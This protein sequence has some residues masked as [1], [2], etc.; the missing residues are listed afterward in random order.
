MEAFPLQSEKFPY[1]IP[2]FIEIAKGSNIK[3]EWN[4]EHKT[5][6]L[7]RILHSSVMYP[8]NYG[9]IPQTLCDDGDPLDV[10]VMSNKVLQPGTI[11]YVRPICH[12]DMEDEKGNDEKLLAIVD[13]EPD[14]HHVRTIDDIA[15][16]KFAEISEFFKTY[17]NLEP[18]K[19]SKVKDWSS[20]VDT[21]RLIRTTHDN[22][23]KKQN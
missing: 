11:V 1:I 8:E 2:A 18:N 9:F 4:D 23:S 7:D 5:L 10:L 20:S 13:S 14:F 22:W 21:M 16:H 19:W 3:Y 12:M 15:K 17:K 6:I